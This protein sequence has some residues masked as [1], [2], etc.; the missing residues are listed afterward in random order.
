LTGVSFFYGILPTSWVD[1]LASL[2]AGRLEFILNVMLASAVALCSY[3]GLHE[4]RRRR[5][6]T[7]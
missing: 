1:G 7:G 4:F 6:T 2:Q 5:Q 3:V